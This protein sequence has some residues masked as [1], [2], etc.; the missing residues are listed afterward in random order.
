MGRES[1]KNPTSETIESARNQTLQDIE[2]VV[3]DDCSP[4]YTPDLMDWYVKQDDRIKYFR[5]SQ[6]VGVQEA[7]NYGNQK[8]ESE[9][10]FV[11]DHDDLSMPNRALI[12]YKYMKKMK[13]VD[14]LT[15]WYWELDVDGQPIKQIYGIPDMTREIF[16]SGDFVWFHSSACYRK[17]TILKHPYRIGEKGETD[18]WIF[19]DD[20]TKA[21]M[22]FKTIKRELANCRRLPWS[23][24]QSRREQMGLQPSYVL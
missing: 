12:S 17:E 5:L 16:E 14:C 18:D 24:M 13:D 7:R 20:W 8:A 3:I 21:G 22:K 6:N 23:Q 19:L 10:I 11:L 2:I 9:L 15:S 1:K 4:D